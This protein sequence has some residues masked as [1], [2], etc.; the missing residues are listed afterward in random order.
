M[1]QVLYEKKINR[2]N[3]IIENFITN[4]KIILAGSTDTKDYFLF[5]KLMNS[6]KK[7]WI[8]IPH[9][10][11]KK[12]LKY[13]TNK[14]TAK[15]SLYSE[16]KDLENSKILIIDKVGILKDIYNLVSFDCSRGFLLVLENRIV[17]FTLLCIAALITLCE[18]CIFV[19]TNSIGLYS[20][21]TTCL[22]AAV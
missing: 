2:K 8:I 19:S 21:I 16:P 3:K 13:I 6:D 5:N 1:D 12:D 20:A 11:S 10:I 18:P 22:R 14:I 7:K 4:K 15:W 9:N 17:F